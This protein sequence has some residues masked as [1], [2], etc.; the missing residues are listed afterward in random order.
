VVSIALRKAKHATSLLVFGKDMML[1][2][3][4]KDKYKRTL[5]DLLLPEGTN[6]NYVLVKDGGA[7]GIG[8]M[9]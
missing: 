8:S 9:R 1:Q 4:G 5:A 6:A 2:T 7:G 3:H